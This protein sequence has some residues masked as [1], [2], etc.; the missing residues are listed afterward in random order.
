MTASINFDPEKCE[1]TYSVTSSDAEKGISATRIA[2]IPVCGCTDCPNPQPAS[3]TA[4]PYCDQIW[5][6]SCLTERQAKELRD[7]GISVSETDPF[8]VQVP[9]TLDR[10]GLVPG[11]SFSPTVGT[12]E[13]TCS[14]SLTKCQC[15][16]PIVAE[17]EKT[18]EAPPARHPEEPDATRTIDAAP[19]APTIVPPSPAKPAEEPIDEICCCL[20]REM[21]AVCLSGPRD[22][23]VRREYPLGSHCPDV[24]LKLAFSERHQ[25]LA[26]LC[27]RSLGKPSVEDLR[28]LRDHLAEDVAKFAAGTGGEETPRI[29]AIRSP[30]GK[31][32]EWREITPKE[33][34]VTGETK[35]RVVSP[36]PAALSVSGAGLEEL[37]E[38][39]SEA[40][41]PPRP[42]E[43]TAT[44]KVVGG[45]G[46]LGGCS[47]V[48]EWT[49]SPEYRILLEERKGDRSLRHKPPKMRNP[50][51]TKALSD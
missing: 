51:G 30:S 10:C 49:A 39:T 48:R 20:S 25:A 12:A 15:P 23:P 8:V 1:A 40:A 24:S 16:P 46:F 22:A 6:L 5:C 37:L 13:G 18:E 19:T 3:D 7:K 14:F 17:E 43:A 34:T 26:A 42:M 35:F 9:T 29:L 27:E 31:A 33:V 38:A 36:P 47:L 21:K 28:K 44:A 11:G 45:G 4:S 50:R 32:A 41:S 2:P